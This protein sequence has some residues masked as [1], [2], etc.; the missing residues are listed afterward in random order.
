[1]GLDFNQRALRRIRLLTVGVGIAGAC[2]V[3]AKQGTRP[4]LGFLMGAALSILNFEGLAKL[5][6]AIGGYR[7]P[8]LAAG[9]LIALRYAL[10]AC[11]LYVILGLLGFAPV[12]VLAGLLTAFGA[13][14]LEVLY[15]LAFRRGNL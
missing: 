6:E 7:K 12:A 15:E 9:M 11:A 5:V 8:G 4:A 10:I 2:F 3:L 1:M 13:V 14:F